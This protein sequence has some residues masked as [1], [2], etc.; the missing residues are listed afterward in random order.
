MDLDFQHLL[1][2]APEPPAPHPGHEIMLAVVGV[3]TVLLLAVA[4]GLWL[5]P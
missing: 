1:N 3:G 5:Q 4:I 2:E